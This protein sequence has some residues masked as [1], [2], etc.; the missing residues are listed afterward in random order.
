MPQ[1]PASLS[2]SV[3]K[4]GKKKTSGESWTALILTQNSCIFVII[5]QLFVWSV[6]DQT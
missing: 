2:P 6:L 5:K 3:E 1:H 4:G